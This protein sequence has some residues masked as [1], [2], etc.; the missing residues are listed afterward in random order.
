MF[1]VRQLVAHN[2]LILDYLSLS[3]LDR[4]RTGGALATTVG[5]D[6]LRE[7]EAKRSDLVGQSNIIC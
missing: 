5:V 3:P 6:Y 4:G 2:P 7:N 1:M